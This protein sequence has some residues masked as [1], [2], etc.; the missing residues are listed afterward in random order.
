MSLRQLPVLVILFLLAACNSADVQLSSTNAADQ[1]AALSNLRFSF[2][3]NLVADSQLNKW[4]NENY[5]SF[6]PQIKGRFRWNSKRELV[7]SPAEP[8]RPATTYT[9]KLNTKIIKDSKFKKLGGEKTHT[10]QTAPLNLETTNFIWTLTDGTKQ[11]IP[12]IHLLFNYT[13]SPQKLSNF[14]SIRLDQENV[15]FKVLTNRK[16]KAIKIAIPGIDISDRDYKVS[17]VLKKGMVRINGSNGTPTENESN[18]ILSSPFQLYINDIA[19]KH[20]GQNGL[21]DIKTSQG[22]DNLEQVKK[23]ISLS[24]KV[25]FTLQK[26]DGGFQIKSEKFL[27]DNIY[28]LVFK[29]GMKG[30]LGGVLFNKYKTNVSFGQLKP[31]VEFKTAEDIYLSKNGKRNIEVTINNIPKVKVIL[32][33]IYEEN[34]L[35]AERYGYYPSE[36]NEDE[37]YYDDAYGS[38][39][40]KGDVVYEK[41]IDTKD[42]ARAR[43]GSRLYNLV[44]DE[45][46]KNFNGIYHLKIQSTEDYWLNDSRFISM[47]DIGMISK[48]GKN[49]IH[50]YT[51]SISSAEPI[52]GVAVAVY[53]NNNQLL[54]KGTTNALGRA[55]LKYTRKPFKGFEPSMI[56]AKKNDDFNYLPFSKTAINTS[57]YD[58]GGR[59]TNRSGIDLFL[60]PERNMYRPGET[61]HFSMIARKTNR[62]NPGSLPVRVRVIRPNGK[63]YKTFKRTLNAQGMI[64]GSFSTTEDALTGTYVIQVFHGNKLLLNQIPIGIEEFVPDRLKVDVKKLPKAFY[65][66]D[67]AKIVLGAMNFFGTP[68]AKR[69]YEVAMRVDEKQFNSKNFQDY[70][71][72]ISNNRNYDE[73]EIEGQTAA[74]G[75]GHEEFIIPKL[76]ANSGLL[77]AQFYTTVFDET[78]RPVSR[79]QKVDIHTQDVYFGVSANGYRYFPLNKPAK[80]SI[81]GLDKNEKLKQATA[82]IDLVKHEYKNVM[83]RSGS[84]YSYKTQEEDKLIQSQKVVL[85]GGKANFFYTPTVSGDYEV[86]ISIPGSN[87]YIKQQFYSYGQWGSSNS[88]SVNK[89][90]TIDISFDK[91]KYM[92][93]DQ[94]KIFFKTPFNGK[95]LVSLESE[96]VISEQYIEVKNRTASVTIP[97]RDKEV[98][99]AYVTATL[100]KAHTESNLPLTVAHGIEYLKVE[101]PNGK[102]KVEIIAKK[103]SRSHKKQKIRIKAKPGSFV[104][105]AAVDNGILMVN[106][107]KTPSPYDFFFGKRKLGVSSYDMYSLLFPEVSRLL[108]HTGGD[109]GTSMN[110]RLNPVKGKRTKLLS[111]WSG[112]KKCNGSG[113]ADFELD[114]PEFNGEMRLMAVACKNGQFGMDEE[115]MIVADP[116]IVNTALPR[117]LSSTDSIPLAVFVTNTTKREASINVSIHKTG[118]ISLIGPATR[119]VTVPA[120]SEEM[121]LFAAKANNDIGLAKIKVEANG[122][123]ETFSNNTELPIRPAA[124][125]ATYDDGGYINENQ[126]TSIK[127]STPKMIPASAKTSLVV[128]RS[129]ILQLGGDF[130]YLVNY[131]HGCSEQII[132]TAFP[133]L[134]YGS[135]ADLFDRG[136]GLKKNAVDHIEQVI[137][138]LKSRQHYNGGVRLWHHANEA[139]WWASVY[140]ADFLIEA[141]QAGFSVDKNMLSTLLN[142]LS[143]QLRS[144]QRITYRYNG[145][146]TKKIAPKEV[147]YS[148][149]VLAKA[150]RPNIPAMNYYK[151]NRNELALDGKYLLAGAYALSGDKKSFQAL[152]P[153]SFAGEKSVTETGGSF[154][155]YERDL[156]LALNVLLDVQADNKQV[157]PMSNLLV[158]QLKGKTH[159]STQ[160]SVYGLLALGKISKQN[161][162]NQA[163]ASVLINGKSIAEMGNKAQRFT[164]NQK[165]LHNIKIAA[166][167]TGKIYYWWQSQGVSQNGI[168][169]EEDKFLKVRRSFYDRHGRVLNGKRFNQNDLIVVKVSLSA[170]YSSSID[171]VVITDLLP[172]GFE[173]ENPRIKEVQGMQWV[174]DATQPTYRDIRDDRIFLFTDGSSRIKNFYYVVRAV[175]PG[176]YKLGPISADAMYNGD[177]HSYHGGGNIS[178]TAKKKQKLN[179]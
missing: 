175:T 46:L 31:D 149:Y 160:S 73:N 81:I 102:M 169:K 59:K 47:S 21:I 49:K 69:N 6:K 28:D 161:E 147:A 136:T 170:S 146:L 97:L 23:Q 79:N 172:A 104:T 83:T 42:L 111:H 118:P 7:F 105:L 91:E 35:A 139:H 53:G 165:D 54:A 78:G 1:V 129:P 100:F 90:G 166:K 13:V 74:N 66:G 113:Y 56:I 18:Q 3:N 94:A 84:Y 4:A 14:L 125:L 68:A 122:L 173:I 157:I 61:V 179:L 32:S 134:Y 131:P 45:V 2:N 121:V 120:E 25:P 116:I 41:T 133:Q 119:K 11:I 154:Y 86:R 167:G 30:E 164:I 101:D 58:V 8:L 144:K 51:N 71:F 87:N 70:D 40:V 114:I 162:R 112:L 12:E 80:F 24:P 50:V 36:S 92:K 39:Y 106:D 126:T 43:S 99:G 140:A 171:N 151:A 124:P 152:L 5:I 174:K 155:S 109:R 178:I 55:E 89:E 34:I 127:I 82:Q 108:S 76:Y 176:R 130:S 148:L 163:R 27:P 150:N 44:P 132:S 67:T 38:D 48:V 52:T 17:L 64:D 26:I 57:K 135:I 153:S 137:Q 93:G 103:K 63:V 60:Y 37:Y 156:A 128:G 138:Q 75:K 22:L 145:K 123:S 159:R 143:S 177:F 77:Q 65:P 117:F 85:K 88:F 9:A 95:L 20:D 10:F 33:K 158:K 29:K 96:N 16:N 72:S 110:Q 168:V 19:A 107:Y 62:S 141:K 98:P 115:H 142:Y 15:P